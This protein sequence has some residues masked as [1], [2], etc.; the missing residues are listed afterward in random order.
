M[1]GFNDCCM[2]SEDR[3]GKKCVLMTEKVLSSRHYDE[4]KMGS[5]NYGR[6]QE[7]YHDAQAERAESSEDEDKLVKKFNE[8]D[9][10]HGRKIIRPAED[11]DVDV[12]DEAPTDPNVS[13][14]DDEE[15]TKKELADDESLFK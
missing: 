10:I 1:R 4:A 15:K 11:V 5:K 12:D 3:K 8:I 2:L 7:K 14:D 13:T 6:I 9:G